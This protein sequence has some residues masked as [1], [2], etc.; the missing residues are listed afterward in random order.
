L[1]FALVMTLISVGQGQVFT[2]GKACPDPEVQQGFD[3]VRYMGKWHS[4][5]RFP[6]RI[7]DSRCN[8]ANYTLNAD[9]TVRVV[10]VAI[11][12]FYVGKADC[13]LF[14]NAVIDG[15]ATIPDAYEPAKLKVNFPTGRTPDEAGDYWVL[16]TDYNTYTV[17][18][19][20]QLTISDDMQMGKIESATVLTRRK[21]EKPP[22]LESLHD[23]LTNNDIDIGNLQVVK[24]EGC[25]Q[26]DASQE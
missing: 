25:P 1:T 15:Y 16:D 11:V 10:N 20:C 19:N 14:R 4:Y 7:Q 23:L 21:G 22:N 12:P 13:P 26:W 18:Y 24:Q 9:N 6:P 2:K 8:L 17:V 5:E 3:V